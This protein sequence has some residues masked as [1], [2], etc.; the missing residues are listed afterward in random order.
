MKVNDLQELVLS[1]ISSDSI[2][3]LVITRLLTD[4]EIEPEVIDLITNYQQAVMAYTQA[5]LRYHRAKRRA[6]YNFE[7]GIIAITNFEGYRDDIDDTWLKKEKLRLNLVYKL[8]DRG[9]NYSMANHKIKDMNRQA[10]Y[11][12]SHGQS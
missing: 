10:E 6:E 9:K 12:R 1:N 3:S 5:K 4:E 2:L 11:N 7:V 8:L